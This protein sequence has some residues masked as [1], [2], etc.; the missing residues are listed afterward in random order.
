MDIYTFELPTEEIVTIQATEDA[1]ELFNTYIQTFSLFSAV[2]I[3]LLSLI[4]ILLFI[5]K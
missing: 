5:K 3:F 4:V 2:I 1:L